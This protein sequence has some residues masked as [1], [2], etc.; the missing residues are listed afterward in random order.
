MATTELGLELSPW[1]AV[2]DGVM[3]GI[4]SGAMVR[5]EDMLR[6]TG[7]LSLENN[8]GFASVRRLTEED[9]SSADRVRLEVNGD[10]RVYQ[11]RIRLDGRFDGI[12]WRAEIPTT[13][14]WQEV[15]ISLA[16]MVPVFR[17]NR[18]RGAGPVVP[19]RIRQI[20]FLVADKQPGP[21]RLDIR[22]IRFL[23]N[24]SD[25]RE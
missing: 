4:S 22:S 14:E 5:E 24:E 21:F 7:E 8:G 19:S 17:G 1:R 18:V 6:F 10:G 13:G 23:E 20:G 25:G 12:A 16:D 11:F 3:G 9:L 2:N 15:E